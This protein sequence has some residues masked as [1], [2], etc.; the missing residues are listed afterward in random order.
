MS[1]LPSYITIHKKTRDTY[2]PREVLIPLLRWLVPL[3]RRMEGSFDPDQALTEYLIQE[4]EHEDEIRRMKGED[5][6][7]RRRRI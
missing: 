3:V 5:R 4:R 7:R 6:R 1:V 2:I